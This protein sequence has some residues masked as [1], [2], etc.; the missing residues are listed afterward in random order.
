MTSDTQT[1]GSTRGARGT[2]P[3]P[4]VRPALA[5]FAVLGGPIAWAVH[6]AVAWSVLEIACLG[7]RVGAVPNRGGEPGALATTLVWVGTGV[8]WLVTLLALAACLVVHRRRRALLDDPAA[9][10]LVTERTGLFVVVGVALALMSLAAI[11]GGALGI[12]LL[13][14]CG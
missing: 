11:T 12:W 7:A 4:R 6:L 3:A 10:A 1:D 14:P 2:P 5:W 9:D 13:E 8:P